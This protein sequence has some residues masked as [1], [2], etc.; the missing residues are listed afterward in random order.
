MRFRALVLAL[1]LAGVLPVCRWLWQPAQAA[2]P[3][4]DAGLLEFLGS[5]DSD[6]EDWHQ[7]LAATGRARNPVDP[8]RSDGSAGN[9][10]A[11]GN[12]SA[13]GSSA[14]SASP[15]AQPP[16]PSSSQPGG[17]SGANSQSRPPEVNQT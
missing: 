3:P 16:P 2:N 6:D 8:P 4:V 10:G 14:P 13:G 5:V 12:K 17:S 1:S 9:P 11:S 15:P 7:Y